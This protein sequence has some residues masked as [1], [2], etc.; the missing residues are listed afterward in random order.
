[1]SEDQDRQQFG[2]P[3]VHKSAFI[4]QGVSL[5]GDVQIGEC[6]SI[7]F[8]CVLRGDVQRIVVGSRTNIQDGSILHG[9]TNGAPTLVGSDVT[10][11]HG[12][13]LHA[14]TIE[15]RAFVGFGARVLDGAIVRTGGMLAAGAVLTPGKVVGTGELWAGNPARLLRP[16]SE[17]EAEAIQ[18]SADRY[19]ALAKR[20]LFSKPLVMQF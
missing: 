10:V 8:N 13:I 2:T 1:M 14:C 5:V 15:D 12:A 3:S 19:V 6:A 18:L 11:G 16:L 4:A 17:K 20:Y 9:T 7:W